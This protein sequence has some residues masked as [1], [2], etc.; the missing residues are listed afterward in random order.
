MKIDINLLKEVTLLVLQRYIDFNG[1]C[2]NTEV[3]YF[4]DIDMDSAVNFQSLPIEKAFLVQSL[5]DDYKCLEEVAKSIREISI[6][7]LDRLADIFKAISYEI[8]KSENR[9]I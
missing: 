7:D 3:D 9:I 8:D 5:E 6:I 1:T 2:L 4:W